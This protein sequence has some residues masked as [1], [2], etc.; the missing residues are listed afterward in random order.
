[1]FEFLSKKDYSSKSSRL[2]IKE[3]KKYDM[4]VFH[5]NKNLHLIKQ[6]EGTLTKRNHLELS[7]QR[8]LPIQLEANLYQLFFFRWSGIRMDDEPSKMNKMENHRNYHKLFCQLNKQA[9]L[10][11]MYR[12]KENYIPANNLFTYYLNLGYSWKQSLR[13]R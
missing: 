10:C 8:N 12:I 5:S 3:K 9:F 4:V 6:T 13:Q 1:M 2:F 11:S 7:S